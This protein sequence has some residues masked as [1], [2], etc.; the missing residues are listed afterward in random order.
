MLTLSNSTVWFLAEATAIASS[1][2]AVRVTFPVS[3]IF[4]LL[5]ATK[6]QEELEAEVA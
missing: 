2:A 4:R 1:C 3:V 6:S 5:F